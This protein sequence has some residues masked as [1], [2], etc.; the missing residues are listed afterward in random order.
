MRPCRP[1]SPRAKDYPTLFGRG[2]LAARP[3]SVQ[4]RS[5]T[6]SGPV[7]RDSL[8][9]AGAHDQPHRSWSGRG[10]PARRARCRCAL[11]RARAVGRRCIA[12]PSASPRVERLTSSAGSRTG[13]VAHALVP[14]YRSSR[15]IVTV[16]SSWTVPVGASRQCSTSHS[17]VKRTRRQLQARNATSGYAKC[18]LASGV[19]SCQTRTLAP[20]PVPPGRWAQHGQAT[21]RFVR[22]SS[23]TTRRGRTFDVWCG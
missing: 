22:R 19:P 1:E 14:A 15:D 17:R 3:A 2:L 4:S 21:L 16:A 12:E 13:R 9:A 5:S 11:G 18:M 8:N 6:R 23:R 10:N 20:A 7:T